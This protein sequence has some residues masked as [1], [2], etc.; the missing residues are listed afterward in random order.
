MADKKVLYAYTVTRNEDGSIDVK[1]AG[2][3]GVDEISVPN[4]YKDIKEV[5]ELVRLK[6]Y[7]DAA[8]VASYN[9]VAK[10]FQDV[11]AQQRAAAEAPATTEETKK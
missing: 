9:G 3:E 8:M 2:L 5:A 10:F 7:T 11:N 4:I 1:S 6:E